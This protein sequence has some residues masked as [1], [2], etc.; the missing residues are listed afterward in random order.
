M[1]VDVALLTDLHM[2]LRS[3]AHSETV[4]VEKKNFTMRM[5]IMIG[6]RE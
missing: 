5:P 4:S 6:A 1:L 3:I 2:R